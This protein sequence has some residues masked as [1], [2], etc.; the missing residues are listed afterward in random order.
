[1]YIWAKSF[2]YIDTFKQEN[3]KKNAQSQKMACN[4]RVLIITLPTKI[5]WWLTFQQN[6]WATISW[7]YLVQILIFVI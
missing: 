4:E 5:T 2:Y 1:M 7:F 3:P 6:M